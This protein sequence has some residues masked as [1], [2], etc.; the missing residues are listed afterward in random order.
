MHVR[1]RLIRS[2]VREGMARTTE[3]VAQACGAGACC[4]GCR[5]SIDQIV[6][7]ERPSQPIVFVQLEAAS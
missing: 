2:L 1:D 5:P 3:E 6:R 7:E 4:G